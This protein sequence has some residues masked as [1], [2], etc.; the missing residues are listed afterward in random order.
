MIA[1]CEKS[2]EEKDTVV[3][4]FCTY[5]WKSLLNARKDIARKQS[6]W[7]RRV[8][9]F[10]DM[11]ESELIRLTCPTCV[12]YFESSFDVCGMSV[13]VSDSD[14]ADAIRMLD[15]DGQAIVLLHYFAEWSDG[16]I[17]ITLGISR[18]TVQFRRTSAL[19]L[20]R[21]MLEGG[22]DNDL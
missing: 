15:A 5:C 19:R 1:T 14:I 9:L 16:R 4:M 10:S 22:R 21:N 8:R 20:L 18:S 7:E 12:H 13:T 6:R 3:R 17:G 2:N 11:R